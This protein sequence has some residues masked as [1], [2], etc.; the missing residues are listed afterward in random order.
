MTPEEFKLELA[1]H[2][3]P[4]PVLVS[5]DATYALGDHAHDFDACALILEGEITLTLAGV[6]T[7]YAAG[8][9]FRVPAG[10]VHEEQAG[11]AGVQYLAGRR[12]P[13][14]RP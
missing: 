7:T 13:K 6:A 2:R 8:D 11:A 1:A 4:P 5:R 9:V 14:D 10:Q 12:D 3:F